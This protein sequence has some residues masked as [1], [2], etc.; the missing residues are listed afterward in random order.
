MWCAPRQLSLLDATKA[1]DFIHVVEKGVDPVYR[2]HYGSGERRREVN[3]IPAVIDEDPVCFSAPR[4]TRWDGVKTRAYAV[5]LHMDE[6]SN[7]NTD[8]RAEGVGYLK[9]TEVCTVC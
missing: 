3:A 5:I 1:T 2:F 6:A 4:G 7:R 8:E 9:G